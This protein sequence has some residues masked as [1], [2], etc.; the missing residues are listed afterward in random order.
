[1][2]PRGP[3]TAAGGVPPLHVPCARAPD[4]EGNYT[5]YRGDRLQEKMHFRVSK[6][7]RAVAYEVATY[8]R[9]LRHYILVHK[10]SPILMGDFEPSDSPREFVC[11]VKCIP[12]G[13]AFALCGSYKT[14]VSF[15]SAEGALC[16]LEALS[17]LV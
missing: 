10:A 12:T 14:V 5:F 17:Q 7:L 1:M 3:A 8:K 16:Q 4:T 13:S 2:V 11:P 15:A 6:P 9:V